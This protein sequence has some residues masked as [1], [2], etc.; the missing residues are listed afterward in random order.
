MVRL[1]QIRER[2]VYIRATVSLE[3][4]KLK[5]IVDRIYDQ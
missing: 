4:S 1:C 5:E 3:M 2:P